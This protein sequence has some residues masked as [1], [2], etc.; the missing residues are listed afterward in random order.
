MKAGA[1]SSATYA[2]VVLSSALRAGGP[3]VTYQEDGFLVDESRHAAFA[4]ARVGH[5][6]RHWQMR[7]HLAACWRARRGGKTEQEQEKEKRS[8][9]AAVRP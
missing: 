2:R 6:D 8:S 1:G 4:C 3:K 7:H 9:Q 5:F